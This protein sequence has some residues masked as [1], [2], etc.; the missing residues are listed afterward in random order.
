[1]CISFRLQQSDS[2]TYIYIYVCV[3]V[4]ICVHV[5]VCVYIHPYSLLQG[6]VPIQGLNLGLLHCR[7]IP[8]CLFPIQLYTLTYVCV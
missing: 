8:F 6:I 4:C 3:C 1:M 5:C 7:Q 2:V